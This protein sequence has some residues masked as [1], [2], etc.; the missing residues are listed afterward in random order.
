MWSRVLLFLVEMS[1]NVTNTKTPAEQWQSHGNFFAKAR[2]KFLRL[3]D[4]DAQAF[5]HILDCMHMP[6]DTQDQQLARQRELQKAYHRAALVPLDVM[7]ACLNALTRARLILKEVYAYVASDC[8]IGIDLLRQ[9]AENSAENV[10]ANTCLI[11]DE[12]LR[13]S[14]ENQAKQVLSQVKAQ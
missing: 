4:E 13:N 12:Q 6:K 10:Y 11:K 14:L 8:V 2:Q 5:R 1:I 3:S 9:A 7:N